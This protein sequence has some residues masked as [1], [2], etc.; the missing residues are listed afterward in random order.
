MDK[1]PHFVRVLVL[2]DPEASVFVQTGRKGK[3]WREKNQAR[4]LPL[5]VAG[6]PLGIWQDPVLLMWRQ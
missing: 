3:A 6:G 1:K 4:A 2:D 5:L